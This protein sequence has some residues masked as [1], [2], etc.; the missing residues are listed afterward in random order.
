MS[1]H[2]KELQRPKCLLQLYFSVRR[3]LISFLNDCVHVVR[4]NLGPQSEALIDQRLWCSYRR[5]EDD[6]RSHRQ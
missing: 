3:N 5:T 6:E 1:Q 4:H 2:V